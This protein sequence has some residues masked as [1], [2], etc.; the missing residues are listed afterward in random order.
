MRNINFTGFR[1]KSSVLVLLAAI[2]CVK[3]GHELILGSFDRFKK[4]IEMIHHETQ[5]EFFSW[6]KWSFF[7]N[8]MI[9]LEICIRLFYRW[10]VIKMSYFKEFHEDSR[11]QTFFYYFR[12]YDE[13]HIDFMVGCLQF[14]N[15]LVHSID[16]VNYRLFLQHEFKL[17]GLEDYLEV[18]KFVPYSQKLCS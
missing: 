1:T 7:N 15:I 11:F 12:N 8:E 18:P 10:T 16:D 3:G 14:I 5:N 9:H 17:L 13:F 2:C 6:M 4:V